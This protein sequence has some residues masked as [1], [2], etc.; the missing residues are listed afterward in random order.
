MAEGASLKAVAGRQK[1][2]AWKLER[3]VVRLGSAADCDIPLDDSLAS[4]YH[5]EIHVAGQGLR[6]KDLGSTNKTMVNGSPI[7]EVSLNDGDQIQIGNTRLQV[8]L[9]ASPQPVAAQAAAAP[10]A[11]APPAAAPPE[12]PSRPVTPPAPAEEAPAPAEKAPAPSRSGR[13]RFLAVILVVVILGFA[14]VIL[15][16]SGEDSATEPTG[17]AG[18]S[19]E[20]DS[21]PAVAF[22]TLSEGARDAGSDT[23]YPENAVALYEEGLSLFQYGRLVRARDT[24]ETV[25]QIAPDHREAQDILRRT[26]SAIDSR[27]EASMQR[28][29]SAM[30]ALRYEEARR[31]LDEV[32]FLLEEGDDRLVEAQR[33]RDRIGQ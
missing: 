19:G 5:A 32:F 27:V 24:L 8:V 28:A 7:S 22:P 31:L 30:E 12:Q 13:I 23:V 2:S 18:A 21:G 1:G 10:P 16:T 11:A 6:V 20:P 29:R 17:G 25:L 4:R 15:L 14:A 26:E 9:G 33:I 3:S